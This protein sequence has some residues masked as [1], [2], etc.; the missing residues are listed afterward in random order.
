MLFA[1]YI[2]TQDRPQPIENGFVMIQG[3]R[4]LQVGQRR[5]LFS[6]PAVRLLDLGNTIL[7]PGLINAHCHLDYTLF[8]GKVP[9]RGRFRDWLKRMGAIAKQTPPLD[10][11][12]GVDKGIRES[13]AYGTTTLCDIS[14]RGQ[15]LG[16]LR[17]SG[18]RSVVFIEMLDLDLS[19]P[20]KYWKQLLERLRDFDRTHHA[21]EIVQ[22]GLS[23]HTPFTVSKELFK[24]AG[25]YLNLKGNIPTSLHLS[26]SRE[27]AAYF[28]NGKGPIAERVRL[29]NPQWPI[30]IQTTPVQYVNGLGWLP[31]LNLAVHLNIVDS[32]D[33]RLL[34]KNRVAV[35]HCPGSHRFFKHPPFRFKQMR[36]HR[37]PLCLGTDSLASNQSLSLFREMRLFREEHPD[38]S[39][40][41]ILS[42]VTVNAARAIGKGFQ[43]GQIRPG[44]LADLIGI[45]SPGRGKGD[46]GI[47]DHVIGYKGTVSFAMVNGNLKLRM[48]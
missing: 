12:K 27:E 4:I 29:L 33:L 20:L 23:P 44:F 38:V 7:L 13:I 45:P 37:I 16:R 42:M 22:W 46:S 17:E 14:T 30:P 32:K 3:N 19:N 6:H 40:Q 25:D 9:Y 48:A 5:N 28:K 35:V 11:R 43:L 18:L 39:P 8:K 10:Y 36:K 34:S 41:E 15:S 31:K 24:L 1:K 21:G 47:L 26:E 2:V